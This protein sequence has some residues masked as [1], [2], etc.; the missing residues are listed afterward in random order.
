LNDPVKQNRGY[1][2]TKWCVIGVCILMCVL[3][4]IVALRL[5]LTLPS[6]ERWFVV[7]AA[8][9]W[10]IGGKMAFG[11]LVDPTMRVVAR[12]WRRT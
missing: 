3:P 7:V 9:A 12:I 5:A 8:V 1:Q 11:S 2:L 10:V 6:T 4:P